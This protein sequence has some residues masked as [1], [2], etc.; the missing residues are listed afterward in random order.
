MGRTRKWIAGVALGLVVVAT[1]TGF[2]IARGGERAHR[3]GARSRHRGRARAHGWRNPFLGA[4]AGDG[5]A[6]GVE[7]RLDDGNVINVAQDENY[8]RGR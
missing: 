8:L 6:Y 5:A 7:V 1:R 2:A 3:F 4:E